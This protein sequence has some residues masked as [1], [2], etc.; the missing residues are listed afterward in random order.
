MCNVGKSLIFIYVHI[1]SYYKLFLYSS[2]CPF[3]MLDSLSCSYTSLFFLPN[4]RGCIL[5]FIPSA[6]VIRQVM[7]F[8]NW[9]SN[10]SFPYVP[11][12]IT[13][14]CNFCPIARKIRLCCS[15]G[16]FMFGLWCLTPL[17]T[18]F[19]LYHGCQLYWWRK[20]EYSEKPPTCRKSLTNLIT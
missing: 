9:L 20:L 19:Q 15:Y 12:I 2:W 16:W 3:V 10:L 8:S 5:H 14:W 4:P 11:S 1:L 18:I 17:L 6:T 13:V 7:W